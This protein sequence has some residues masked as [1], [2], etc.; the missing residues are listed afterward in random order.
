LIKIGVLKKITAIIPTF[1]EELNIQSALNSVAFADEIIVI[2][3]FS[4]D[5]TIEIVK[6]SKAK[7]IQRVFDDF[8]SQKN[9]AIEKATHEWIFLLDADETVS[10]VL[11][12]EIIKVVNSNTIFS[13]FK[14]YRVSFYKNKQINFSG[15]RKDK[16]VRLFKKSYNSYRGKVHEKI[17]TDGKVGFLNEKIY[18]YSFR[19]YFQFKYKLEGY[20]KLQAQ[21]LML[22]GKIVTPYHLFIKPFIRFCIHFFMRFGF[23]DGYRGFV[24]SWLHAYGVWRRYVETLKLKYSKREKVNS[25]QDF[26]ALKNEKDISIVIV[27]YKS[28]KHLNS[29]L[30]S[31]LKIDETNFTFEVI[32][33]DNK[34]NDGTLEEFT[35]RFKQFKFIENTGNNGFANGCNVGAINSVGRN[36]L[37]LNPDTIASEAAIQEMSSC[38]DANPT[39]GIVSCNQLNSNGSFEDSDRIFP[40]LLTL[41]GLT[42]ALFRKFAKKTRQN[43]DEIFPDWVSGSVVCISR[44]WFQ[45]IQGWNEDYWMY[46]EDVDLSKKVRDQGGEVA[47][48]KNAEIIH[49]HGGASRVNIKTASITK[50]EVLISK[51]VY[52]SN[53]FKGLKRFLMLFLVVVNSLITKLVLALLGLLLFFIPKLKLNLYLFVKMIAYY[54]HSLKKGTWLSARSMNLPF[55]E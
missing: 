6:R 5:R 30:E 20:A 42:R 34:S 1:N 52:I 45:K 18:H 38:L 41:F 22:T 23:L 31:L 50:T 54:Y 39:Y 48:V 8:S 37:F 3:S 36:L 32:V 4:T 13:A 17:V 19:N 24:I 49:N 35:K 43:D 25:I 10:T 28:W 12:D 29:C 7:L 9:Y 15:W 2:D 27:N 14:I 44:K 40:D 46:Y 16:V 55:K 11:K 21:E 47:L 53:H 26:D 33:V 51:H